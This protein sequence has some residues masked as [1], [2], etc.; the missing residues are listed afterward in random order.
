MIWG[1]LASLIGSRARAKEEDG[2]S[3]LDGDGDIICGGVE[4]NGDVFDP[5]ELEDGID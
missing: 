2:I 3:A 1:L 4:D 5:H